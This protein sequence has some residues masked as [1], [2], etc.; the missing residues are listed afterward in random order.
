MTQ[1]VHERHVGNIRTV[2]PFTLKQ[3]NSSG[4]LTAV[5]LSSFAPGALS[6]KM[7][8]AATGATVIALTTTGVSFTA[9]SAGQGQYKFSPAGVL[10]AGYFDGFVVLTDSTETDDFPLHPGGLRIEISSDTQTAKQAYEA[11]LV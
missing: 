10:S 6:F 9:S 8:N 4:V 5:D 1:A 7:I 2:L 11:A 3:P